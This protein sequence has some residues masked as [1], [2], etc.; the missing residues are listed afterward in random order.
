MVCVG[1]A[2]AAEVKSRSS[3]LRWRWTVRGAEGEG[4]VRMWRECRRT[5]PVK[6]YG[7]NRLIYARNGATG[8]LKDAVTQ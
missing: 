8:G 7:Y 2:E 4:E 3:V 5:W 6:L 1:R